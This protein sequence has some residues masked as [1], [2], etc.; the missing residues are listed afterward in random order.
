MEQFGQVVIDEQA[1]KRRAVPAIEDAWR[2]VR[3]LLAGVDHECTHSHP[4]DD[5]FYV[6]DGTMTLLVGDRWIDAPK[7]AFVLVPGGI[8]HDFENRGAERAGVLNFSAPGT[9]EQHMP[10]IVEWFTDNPPSEAIA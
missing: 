6:I 9:F 4:E 2:T 7:G 5:V 8:T 1:K 10:A 3:C